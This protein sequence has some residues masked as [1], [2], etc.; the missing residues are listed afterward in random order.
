M[1]IFYRLL[2]NIYVKTKVASPRNIKKPPLSVIA[3]I[4][5]LEPTAGSLPKR[6]IKSGIK[7]PIIAASIR[8]KTM[9]LAITKPK[10]AL[11]YK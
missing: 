4:K 5:T 11:L 2:K 3:V 8:F 10:S 9:A 6:C 1:F 7:T